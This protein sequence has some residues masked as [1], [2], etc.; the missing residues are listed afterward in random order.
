[1]YFMLK[2]YVQAESDYRKAIEIDSESAI[3]HNYYG[4]LLFDQLKY[5]ESM[6]QFETAI[7]LFPQYGD[8]LCNLGSAYGVIGQS[9]MELAMQDSTHVQNHMQQSQKNFET[10]IG[11]F[12]ESIRVQSDYIEPYR[13]LTEIYRMTGDLE[14]TDKYAGLTQQ[15]EKRQKKKNVSNLPE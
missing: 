1:M 4:M 3:A 5:P 15:L 13:M 6:Q 11:Y 7:R 8:A 10:A 14:N 9:E 12:N 2:E